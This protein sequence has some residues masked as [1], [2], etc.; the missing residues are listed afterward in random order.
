[1]TLNLWK[2]FLS[3]ISRKKDT[4]DTEPTHPN[5]LRRE[6]PGNHGVIEYSLDMDCENWQVIP[7]FQIDNEVNT[8]NE[9]TC[10]S[11][12]KEYPIFD[13]WLSPQFSDSMEEE[14]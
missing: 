13:L 1:M 2:R 9:W 11:D 3:F 4:P 14:E 5:V 8:G 7:P 12:Q 6:K 10:H